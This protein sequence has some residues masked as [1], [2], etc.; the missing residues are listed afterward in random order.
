MVKLV[1]L[2]CFAT[3]SVPYVEYVESKATGADEM[4]RDGTQGIWAPRNALPVGEC[5]VAADPITLPSLALVSI[6]E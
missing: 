1:H 2:V 3:R 5:G 4:S 6:F